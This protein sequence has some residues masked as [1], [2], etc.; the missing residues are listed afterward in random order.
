MANDV[1]GELRRASAGLLYP[2]ES[3]VP[4]EPFRWEG[5]GE[6]TPEQLGQLPTKGERR[7][8]GKPRPV[9]EVPFKEFFEELAESEDA[10]RF[11][12]MEAV[13]RRGLTDLR[14]FRV[15]KVNVDIYLVGR[16]RAGQWLG[17][18]TASVET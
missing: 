9:K 11:R 8:K 15:G 4:F 2:S 7:R 18:H 6:P 13:L 10:G 3:D 17:L 14:V 16:D 5:A 12:E 1:L